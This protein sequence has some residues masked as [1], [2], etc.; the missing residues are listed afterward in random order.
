MD[1]SRPVKQLTREAGSLWQR[2]LPILQELWVE[3]L[4]TVQRFDHVLDRWL[5]KRTGRSNRLL[6]KV[7]IYVG[8]GIAALWFVRIT[9]VLLG[10]GLVI[11]VISIITRPK[12]ESRRPPRRYLRRYDPDDFGE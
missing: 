5:Q 10:I 2:S 8:L 11:G 3:G 6:F 4:R 7:L 1:R 9:L 12:P